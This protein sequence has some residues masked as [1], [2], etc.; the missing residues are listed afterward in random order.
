MLIW[1]VLCCTFLG[2]QASEDDFFVRK[3]DGK[4]KRALKRQARQN[5]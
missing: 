3:Q 5:G 1:T 2:L 4:W